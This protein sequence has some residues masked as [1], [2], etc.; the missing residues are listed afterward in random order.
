MA[1]WPGAGGCWAG[2][3]SLGADG[4]TSHFLWP[5]SA[6]HYYFL[7]LDFSNRENGKLREVLGFAQLL[8]FF[9]FLFW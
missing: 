1:T 6:Q 9:F 4:R 5:L 2:S 7:Y 3:T 8:F